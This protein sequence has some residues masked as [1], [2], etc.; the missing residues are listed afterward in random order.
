MTKTQNNA[1]NREL[2]EEK[3]E[4]ERDLEEEEREKERV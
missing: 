2:E 4:A 3:P 1:S